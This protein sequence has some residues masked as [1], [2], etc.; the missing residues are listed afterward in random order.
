ML[1]QFVSALELL[2]AQVAHE[3]A[4]RRVAQLVQLQFVGAREDLGTHAAAIDLDGM[5]GLHVF[6]DHV[7]RLK[8]PMTFGTREHTSHS[9]GLCVHSKDV[10]L[11]INNVC[12][13]PI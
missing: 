10:Y 13:D 5:Q 11:W 12:E 7:V 6:A 8:R 3:L 2:P 9:V 1:A 4:V